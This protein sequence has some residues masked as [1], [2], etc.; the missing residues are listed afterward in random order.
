MDCGRNKKLMLLG[1]A[2]SMLLIGGCS[3]RQDISDTS[4]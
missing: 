2:L 1:V 3:L 4:I